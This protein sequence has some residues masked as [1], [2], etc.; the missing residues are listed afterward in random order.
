V[1]TKDEAVGQLWSAKFK[2]MA[3]MPNKKIQGGRVK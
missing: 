1:K 2:I 3:R